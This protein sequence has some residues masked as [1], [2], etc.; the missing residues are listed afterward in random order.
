MKINSS[1]QLSS[2]FRPCMCHFTLMRNKATQGQFDSVAIYHKPYR[3]CKFQPVVFDTERVISGGT[4]RINEFYRGLKRCLAVYFTGVFIQGYKFKIRKSYNS[5][6]VFWGC[7]YFTLEDICTMM[8]IME[9]YY[10]D[11]QLGR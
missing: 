8:E 11:K 6:A 10:T 9:F 4:W 5:E 2:G 3:K 1:W 7:R